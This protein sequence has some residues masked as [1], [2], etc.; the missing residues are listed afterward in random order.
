MSDSTRTTIKA[1]SCGKM[2]GYS[3]KR[4]SS[5]IGSLYWKPRG[6]LVWKEHS[7][8]IIFDRD[9]MLFFPTCFL[10]NACHD[11]NQ[12][13]TY[14]KIKKKK[15][16]SAYKFEQSKYRNEMKVHTNCIFGVL[17][18]IPTL[19]GVN[20]LWRGPAGVGIVMNR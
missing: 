10:R 14:F 8:L 15:I 9:T 6:V 20:R 19:E 7:F 4:L 16:Q 5:I 3:D 18:K 13:A 1:I 12:V 11:P 17:K 2:Q